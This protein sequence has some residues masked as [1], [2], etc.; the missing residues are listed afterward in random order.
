[1]VEGIEAL[2]NLA[3]SFMTVL[4]CRGFFSDAD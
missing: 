1:M 2:K 4:N 3:V